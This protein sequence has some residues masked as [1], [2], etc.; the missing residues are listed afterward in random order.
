[1]DFLNA[2]GVLKMNYKVFYLTRW[3]K[4]ARF[5]GGFNTLCQAID[6]I[7]FLQNKL[8]NGNKITFKIVG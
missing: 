5:C 1:M 6:H 2:T 3:F 4:E 7:D 8:P